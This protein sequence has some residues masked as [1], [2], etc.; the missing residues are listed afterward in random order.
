MPIGPAIGPTMGLTAADAAGSS[1]A[2]RGCLRGPSPASSLCS[3]LRNAALIK[4]MLMHS[5]NLPAPC[6]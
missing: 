4:Q 3:R 5:L 2:Y 6:A 1:C